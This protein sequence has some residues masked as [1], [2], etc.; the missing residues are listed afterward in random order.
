M[1]PELFKR[2]AYDFQVDVWSFGVIVYQ[3]I[4]N[5]HPLG[6]IKNAQKYRELLTKYEKR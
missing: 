2:N 3:L 1:A 5:K 6:E 4:F